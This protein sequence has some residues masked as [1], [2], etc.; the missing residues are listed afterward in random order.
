M[1]PFRNPRNL[2]GGFGLP[3]MLRIMALLKYAFFISESVVD[4][5]GVL[6][7]QEIAPRIPN[8]GLLPSAF[9]VASNDVTLICPVCPVAL[10]AASKV[11]Q[12]KY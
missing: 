10:R 11:L 5:N 8:A 7:P 9:D 12:L 2:Q 1:R 4:R 3:F 6:S